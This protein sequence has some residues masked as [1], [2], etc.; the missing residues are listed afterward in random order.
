MVYLSKKNADKIIRELSKTKNKEVG[1]II[2]RLKCP[3]KKRIY[4]CENSEIKKLLKKAFDE[5]RKIKIRYYSPHSDEHTNRIIDIYQIHKD[6]I[7]AFCHLREEERTFIIGR[8]N[9]AAILDEG[10]SIPK[11][12]SPE[13]IIL[14]K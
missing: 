2:K 13:N 14:N 5:K 6:C 4:V 12:W 11:G 9:S 7:V 8:I 10:Y 1:I 3:G